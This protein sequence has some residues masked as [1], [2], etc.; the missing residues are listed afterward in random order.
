MWRPTTSCTTRSVDYVV[1]IV[2]ATRHPEKFGMPDAKGVDRLRCIAACFARHHRGVA[3]ARRWSVGRDYVIPAGRRRG[4]SRTCC[5][6][7]LVLTYDALADEISLGDRDQPDPANGGP[8]TGECH[9]AARPFG[10][11]GDAYPPRL[12]PVIGDYV[13]TRGRPAVAEARGD[14]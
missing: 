3:R 7:G 1:R 8:A 5:G 9:S 13:Q 14:S 2:T 6:T 11:A 4:H 12:P 10:A